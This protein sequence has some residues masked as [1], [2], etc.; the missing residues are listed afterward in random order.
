MIRGQPRSR[1]A[2]RRDR[3]LRWSSADGRRGVRMP[4][5]DGIRRC[6]L[7]GSVQHPRMAGR[8]RARAQGGCYRD[9]GDGASWSRRL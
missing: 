2:P 5:G 4:G 9:P 6:D 3:Q 7:D 8:E 1:A